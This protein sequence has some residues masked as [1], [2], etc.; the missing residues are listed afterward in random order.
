VPLSALICVDA[1]RREVRISSLSKILTCTQ[2]RIQV[3]ETKSCHCW[4]TLFAHS[5][6]PNRGWKS[7]G[8]CSA[9]RLLDINCTG[10]TLQQFKR[11]RQYPAMHDKTKA[12]PDQ[13]IYQTILHYFYLADAR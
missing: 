8:D 12:V 6:G 11:V 3:S 4:H 1:G 9:Y 7:R 13:I 10:L 5:L 2:S